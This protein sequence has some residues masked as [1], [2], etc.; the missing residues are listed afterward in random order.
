M[1]LPVDVFHLV[2][3]MLMT[4]HMKSRLHSASWSLNLLNA[5]SDFVDASSKG[6]ILLLRL[7][8]NTS[9]SITL[10]I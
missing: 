9:P 10:N 5:S 1:S 2:M 3:R 4:A 8:V 7:Q 6:H